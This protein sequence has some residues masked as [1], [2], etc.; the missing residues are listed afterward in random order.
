MLFP[1][2]RTTFR[3]ASSVFAG[4]GPPPG[5]VTEKSWL[6]AEAAVVQLLS[7]FASVLILAVGA[8][9]VLGKAAPG[10]VPA[11]GSTRFATVANAFARPWVLVA[12][13]P[14]LP[15]VLRNWASPHTVAA[16]VTSLTTNLVAATIWLQAPSASAR[17]IAALSGAL[18]TCPPRTTT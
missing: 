5:V 2:L 8:T 14:T 7:T 10:D 18:P 15:P 6:Q 12:V 1:G 17:V 9:P 3:A 13:A 4:A 16:V 11:V